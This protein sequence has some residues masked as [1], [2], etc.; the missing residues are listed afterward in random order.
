[1]ESKIVTA[2]SDWWAAYSRKIGAPILAGFIICILCGCH[3]Q[4]I[5]HEPMKAA[6]A[7]NEFL[8][9]L[10]FDEDYERALSMVDP[11]ARPTV[12]ADELRSL[13]Q[14]I[15]D[16]RGTLHTLRADSY[17]MMSGRSIELLYVGAYEK[18]LL[19]HR[20]TLLGD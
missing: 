14:P 6:F 20:V 1:M 11:Q 3:A 13:V 12:N 8:K 18:G 7:A 19:Y 9:A 4:T 16:E 17:L 5:K 15:K 2:S 10:F